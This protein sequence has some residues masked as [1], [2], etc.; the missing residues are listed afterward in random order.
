MSV[1]DLSRETYA[2]VAARR[3]QFDQLVWQVP[4]LTL[5]AQA[6]LFRSP[7]HLTQGRLLK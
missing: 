6:F 7:C 2:I 5:T 3:A 4:V 1:P